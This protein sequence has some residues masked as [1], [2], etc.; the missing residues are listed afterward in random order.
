M[1]VVG[2]TDWLPETAVLGVHGAEQEVAFWEDQESWEDWPE[3]R[4]EGLADK[5]SLGSGIIV[6]VTDW[7]ALPPGPVQVRVY[8]VVAVGMT[9]CVPD[10]GCEP[11]QPPEAVQ[12]VVFADDQDNVDDSPPAMDVGDAESD[13]EGRGCGA[14]LTVTDWDAL[15]PGP[16]QVSV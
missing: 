16:V 11:D 8:T 13:T 5:V 1:V 6:T 9:D 7:D 12:E 2:D 3:T 4:E 15:P 14:T 10:V